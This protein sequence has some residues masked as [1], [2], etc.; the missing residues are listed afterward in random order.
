[1]RWI[2]P[3]IWSRLQMRLKP[4]PKLWTLWRGISWVKPP[5]P[6]GSGGLSSGIIF[7]NSTAMYLVRLTV[8]AFATC[9]AIAP[10]VLAQHKP[11]K[12][13][14]VQT[15]EGY[16]LL[17]DGEPYFIKGAGGT[18]HMDRLKAYGGNSVR[19]WS[20]NNGQAILDEAQRLGLTVTMGINM[21]RERHGFDYSDTAA[22]AKQL[23]RVRQEVLLYKDHPALLAWG[24]GNELNL[25][26]TN[27]KVWDA[28]NDIVKMIHE[29][30]PNHPAGTILAGLNK[31]EVDYIK[32]V[33]PDM[34]FLGINMYGDLASLTQRVQ[35]VGWKGAYMVTEWGPTGH[36]ESLQ[37]EWKMPIEETSSEKASVYRR[38]YEYSIEKD[39]D[40]CL[41]SYVFLW[42]QKQERTPTWYGLF[43][44]KGEESEV[45][46]VMEYLWAGSWPVNR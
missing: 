24:I 46:D 16:T 32:E 8:A 33:S 19:T 14:I 30:D 6:V 15:A 12:A 29:I 9:F 43:T 38:R 13:E 27:P 21:A 40:Q 10:G 25:Q 5:I 7:F 39:K 35:N 31:K 41:G 22:V 42:G 26:Y 11:V 18:S 36:W 37:T 23:E 44:E 1:M 20:T 34:D 28:V 4:A 3:S 2:P 17:R 45:M